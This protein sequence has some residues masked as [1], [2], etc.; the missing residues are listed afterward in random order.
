MASNDE[1][2]IPVKE[3]PDKHL[4]DGRSTPDTPSKKPIPSTTASSRPSPQPVTNGQNTRNENSSSD[5]T[6][7]TQHQDEENANN[8]PDSDAT[9]S[10]IPDFDWEEFLH[11]YERAI[12]AATNEENE[13][14]SQFNHLS[15]VLIDKFMR[16]DHS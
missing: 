5:K 10:D 16:L 6:A 15:E 7:E 2:E 1:E 9:L 14:L 3:L 12:Q 13:L 4:N 8:D 11:K